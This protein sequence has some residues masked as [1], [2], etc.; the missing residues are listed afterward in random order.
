MSN[1]TECIDLYLKDEVV[2][3]A[4]FRAVIREAAELDAID[5]ATALTYWHNL[6]EARAERQRMEREGA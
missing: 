4:Q 2:T 1:V 5:H 3:D 6:G